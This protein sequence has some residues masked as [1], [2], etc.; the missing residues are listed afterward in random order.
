VNGLSEVVDEFRAQF[1][2]NAIAEGALPVEA[3][4]TQRDDAGRFAKAEPVV[5][6][7]PAA[8]EVVDEVIDPVA[9]AEKILGKFDTVD[10]M[11]RAYQ[12]LER[13]LGEPS[14]DV[15]EFRRLEAELQSLKQQIQP[16]QPQ[17]D[18]EQLEE[19]FDDNPQLVPQTAA[20][21]LNRQDWALYNAAM[22]RWHDMAP[23]AAAAY[24]RQLELN[25]LRYEM[26][27][28]LQETARPA[29]QQQQANE[30]KVAVSDLSTEFP[31]IVN[32]KFAEQMMA[33]AHR[34]PA[35]L[36]L[37][38]NGDLASKTETLRSL[39]LM[40]RGRNRD[41]LVNAAHQNGRQEQA[42]S[43]D[44]KREASVLTASSNPGQT[45]PTGV[46]AFREAFRNTPEFRKA[47]GLPLQ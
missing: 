26:E 20:D 24:E 10:D 12:E 32:D 2:E 29:A 8:K 6:E 18:P 35:L 47:A 45:V 31:E 42:Q 15:N 23:R 25:Q 39:A 21:A 9:P 33:E 46:D 22:E 44:A 37:L 27:S 17:Y 13:K 34:V 5:E 16:A 28:K 38:Q 11:T 19:W 43:A 7:T 36:S 4:E 14:R 3:R 30:F 41:N 40:A 1:R